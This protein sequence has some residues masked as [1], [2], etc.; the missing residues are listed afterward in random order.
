MTR[1]FYC[2][3]TLGGLNLIQSCLLFFKLELLRAERICIR[4]SQVIV[5]WIMEVG[6]VGFSVLLNLLG[7]FRDS[8]PLCD[9]DYF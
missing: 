4:K 8:Q 1:I 3:M 5:K 2:F 7:P 6:F 9:C